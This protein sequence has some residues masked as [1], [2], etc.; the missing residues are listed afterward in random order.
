MRINSKYQLTIPKHIRDKMG[1]TPST[2]VGFIEE[3]D[4]V[5]LVKREV[6]KANSGWIVKLPHK[7]I[8][9]QPDDSRQTAAVRF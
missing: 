9:K 4:R 5:Y 2:E 3:G 1:L 8:S 6:E 7:G